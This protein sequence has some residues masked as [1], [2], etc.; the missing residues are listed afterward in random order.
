MF[1]LVQAL[2]CY[3]PKYNIDCH[4]C[5][6]LDPIKAHKSA[7]QRVRV[8]AE[9]GNQRLDNFLLGR[10]GRVPRTRV[11][12]MIR[13]GEVRV[14]KKRARPDYRLKPGDEVRIPPLRIDAG[15][16]PRAVP[17]ASLIER[18]GAAI[19]FENEH[20]LVL[21]KPAGIAVHA[22]SGL[23]Y[24]IIDAMRRLRPDANIELAHRLDRDTSGCLLFALH[25][26]ALLEL[27]ELLADNRIGKR[28]RAIVRGRWPADLREIDA[29]LA[30]YHLPNGERRVRA[31]A[32][33]KSAATRF[34]IL[35]SGSAFSHLQIELLSGRTH[36]IRVHCQ[37]A[38]H[39]I[40]GDDKYGDAEFNKRLR[41]R[42][43][44]R[45]MLHAVSLDLPGGRFIPEQ[46]IGS[47]LPDEF[48]RLDG[49]RHSV[50]EN[51]A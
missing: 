40:A 27:H 42:G 20:I 50:S 31:D 11:Y 2:Q 24:G 19:L 3:P 29:P 28:Y 49:A 23:D 26:D 32:R 30:R 4:D 1:C 21:D 37:L 47:P 39:P 16:T 45:L 9:S 18:L 14:N 10:L 17:S 43:L 22:G 33:G 5:Q 41:A 51:Q 6:P 15:P 12:R 44:R 25:R 35:A 38:E 36:Q 7:A 46:I 13:K 34:E 48:E 8:D